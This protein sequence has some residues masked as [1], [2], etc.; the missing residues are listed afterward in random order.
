VR[1]ELRTFYFD[2]KP[3]IT[4]TLV[5]ITFAIIVAL[6]LYPWWNPWW[7]ELHDLL[8]NEKTKKIDLSGVGKI[9]AGLATVGGGGFALWRWTVDQRWRRVQYAQQLV[10]EFFTSEN[11]KLALRM[12]DV[13]GNIELPPAKKDGKRWRTV[14]VSEELLT[15]SLLT[16]DQQVDF[17][18]PHLSVRLI[19]DQFFTDLSMFQH[20]LDA[21]LILLRNIRPYLAYWIKGLNGY[22]PIY[23]IKVAKQINVFLQAFDYDAVLKLS[24]TMGYWPKTINLSIEEK[25]E[26]NT[27]LAAYCRTEGDRWFK[28]RRTDEKQWRRK[29]RSDAK[30]SRGPSGSPKTRF[31]IYERTY[32]LRSTIGERYLS[33]VRSDYTDSGDGEMPNHGVESILWDKVSNKQINISRFFKET[34]DDG[35]TLQ[36]ILKELKARNRH[37]ST[38]E[39]YR[40]LKPTL[41]RIGAATL[42]PS[43]MGGKSSGL[44]F[45]YS[46]YGA[47][48]DAEDGHIAFVPWKAFELLLSPERVN[49][50]AG[51]RP[52]GDDDA[53]DELA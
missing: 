10:K 50:F 53:C 40:N 7:T 13:Q 47:G 27:G 14:D 22:G 5:A 49:I 18:E 36:A 33:V 26:T 2:Y 34:A 17:D 37:R 15:N 4:R 20:H 41:S 9:L 42:A 12:L 28:A 6:V 38:S 19:F 45:H 11:T 46:P 24:R 16:F 29:N 48:L 51:E 35:P 39:W 21:K 23:S 52:D 43:T 30:N 44:T 25:V 3:T 1:A 31:P 32:Q 8:L